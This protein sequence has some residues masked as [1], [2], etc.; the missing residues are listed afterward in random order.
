MYFENITHAG[1]LLQCKQVSSADPYTPGQFPQAA[2]DGEIATEWQPLSNI[3]ASILINMAGSKYQSLSSVYFNWASR[4]PHNATV[5]LSN[6]T[7]ISNG[8]RQLDG[9]VREIPISGITPSD[10]YDAV[11]AAAATVVPYVGNETVQELGSSG[12]WTGDWVE[13]VIEGCWQEDGE[14]RGATVAEFVL[15]GSQGVVQ[16]GNVTSGR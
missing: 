13:L 16:M 4:P 10:P 8:V 12:V 15:V 1:N 11:K 9:D 6:N 3:T 14:G 5:H 2:I 7:K